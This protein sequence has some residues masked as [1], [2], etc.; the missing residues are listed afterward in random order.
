M[1]SS[2]KLTI[3]FL[4]VGNVGQKVG[5]VTQQIQLPPLLKQSE[6]GLV[7]KKAQGVPC[8]HLSPLL[9]D[10]PSAGAA[11][12]AECYRRPKSTSVEFAP[13]GGS[14]LMLGTPWGLACLVGCEQRLGNASFSTARTLRPTSPPASAPG[15]ILLILEVEIGLFLKVRWYK[16]TTC[17]YIST[18]F[19]VDCWRD[20]IVIM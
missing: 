16:Y 17:G 2:G 12:P 7:M 6:G 4:P 8:P 11:Q 14:G 10:L 19:K 18:E 15:F 5:Q 9:S 20:I 3:I 1:E 13:Q